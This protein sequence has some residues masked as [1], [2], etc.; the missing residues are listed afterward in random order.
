MIKCDTNHRITKVLLHSVAEPPLGLRGHLTSQ[1]SDIHTF[2]FLSWKICCYQI[3]IKSWPHNN[4]R[5]FG[6]GV[7]DLVSYARCAGLSPQKS[8]FFFFFFLSR[9]LFGSF[10]FFT[11]FFFGSLKLLKLICIFH[12][13][14]YYLQHTHSR[15]AYRAIRVR[16]W[17]SSTRTWLVRVNFE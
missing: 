8:F 7:R 3:N 4:K 6:V 1:V 2:F 14:C 12:S 16:V 9:L 17:L 11:D 10:I 5:T 13:Y 15:G